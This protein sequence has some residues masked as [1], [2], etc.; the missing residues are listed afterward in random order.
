MGVDL[1]LKSKEK[2]QQEPLVGGSERM[3]LIDFVKNACLPSKYAEYAYETYISLFEQASTCNADVVKQRLVSCL[4][5][6]L[7]EYDSPYTMKELTGLTGIPVNVLSQTHKKYF[8]SNN[9]MDI[10]PKHLIARFCAKSHLP[11]HATIEIMKMLDDLEATGFEP[12][13]NPATIC[14]AYIYTYVLRNNIG[15]SLFD[16][17]AATGVSPASV[18][19]YIKNYEI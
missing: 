5:Q 14:S 3:I 18:R 9:E 10:R 8:F 12:T 13:C 2:D 1:D 11:R 15:L 19:R 4:Y 17:C 7:L 16:L 6:I